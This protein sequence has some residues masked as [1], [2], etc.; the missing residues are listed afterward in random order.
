MPY[1]HDMLE[2][3]LMRSPTDRREFRLGTVGTVRFTGRLSGSALAVAGEKSWTFTGPSQFKR[4]AFATTAAG[5]AVGEARLDH[6]RRGGTLRW[7][8][9]EFALRPASAWKER[10]E[11]VQDHASIAVF[12]GKG[13]GKRPVRVTVPSI[14]RV[15]RG[16]LLFGAFVV[17]GLAEEANTAAGAGATVAATG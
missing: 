1:A 2:L 16:L 12:D 8:D 17:R 10:Y 6:L 9:G 7:A 5:E 4:Q 3:E 15:Q 14:A 13:W 11:L